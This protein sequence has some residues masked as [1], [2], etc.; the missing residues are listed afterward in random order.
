MIDVA[1]I[2]TG[3]GGDVK[4]IGNDF[5]LYYNGQNNIYFGLFG[6]N[7]EPL[8]NRGNEDQNFEWWGNKL[9]FDNNKS[10]QFVSN[11]ERFLQDTPLTSSG[12]VMIENAMKGSLK[13][14][15]DLGEVTVKVT[16]VATDRINAEFKWYT[17]E[18]IPKT[19]TVKYGK[20]EDGDFFVLDFNNDDFL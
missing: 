4:L 20:S 11:V 12:R 16:I 19:Y 14:M 1:F 7:K 13:F 2:E 9:F 18:G 17:L 8:P 6:G 3:N 5:Q 10:I 15:S